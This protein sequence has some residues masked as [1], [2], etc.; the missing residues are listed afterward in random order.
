MDKTQKNNFA[1]NMQSSKAVQFFSVAAFSNTE[2][3]LHIGAHEVLVSYHY[4]RKRFDPYVEFIKELRAREGLFMVDSGAFSYIHG[5]AQKE[6]YTEEFWLPHVEEYVQ[7]LWDY[8]KYIFVAANFDMEQ[9]VGRDIVY[10]WDEKYFQPLM[11]KINVTFI[12]HQNAEE[13]DPTGLKGLE[14]Y[15]KRYPYVGVN[16]QMKSLNTKVFQ[17]VN[18]YNRICHGMAWTDYRILNKTP[19]F[20]VDSSSWL[21]GQRFG[22]T[23]FYDGANFRS[24]DKKKKGIRK[25]CAD[26][27]HNYGINFTDLMNEKQEAVTKFNLVAW[28]CARN[29]YISR[30]N[31][32]LKNKEVIHYA[33]HLQGISKAKKILPR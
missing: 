28:V 19:L 2:Y 8:S 24:L 23:F 18:R 22:A 6:W 32:K 15:C 16:A 10:K 27:C 1:Y 12:S 26:L 30:A 17:M 25:Y 5:E 31:L 29:D 20:T 14:Y 33:Q 3:L 9:Y 7:F 13:A 4:F 11:N 21:M